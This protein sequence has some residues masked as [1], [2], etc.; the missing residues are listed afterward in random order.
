V[1]QYC[2]SQSVGITFEKLI[3]AKNHASIKETLIG[4]INIT[5]NDKLKVEPRVRVDL[6][7]LPSFTTGLLTVYYVSPSN[8]LIE[9]DEI[10]TDILIELHKTKVSF[11]QQFSMNF[12]ISN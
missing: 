12:E 5:Y 4:K 11:A 10:I 7:N 8:N 3:D 9:A 1:S 6:R 2:I